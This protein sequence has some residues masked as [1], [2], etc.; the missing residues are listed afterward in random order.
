VLVVENGRLLGIIAQSDLVR[1]Q[2]PREPLKGE[3][4]LERI[5]APAPVAA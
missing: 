1:K 5:S 2:G 4:V 3:E